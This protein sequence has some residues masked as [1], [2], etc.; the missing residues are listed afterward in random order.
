MDDTLSLLYLHDYLHDHPGEPFCREC[1]K[2]LAQQHKRSTERLT[3][4]PGRTHVQRPGTCSQC[5]RHTTVLQ[6]VSPR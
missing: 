6:A 3:E 2:S 4:V 1:L 5:Q